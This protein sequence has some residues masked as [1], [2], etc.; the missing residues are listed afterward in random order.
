MKKFIKISGMSC[1]HCS[2]RVLK[3]LNSIPRVSSATIDLT[4]GTAT[5]ECDSNVTNDQ[6][7]NA[8]LDL[9]FAVL[10]IE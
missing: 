6:L 8:I 10:K 7:T 5:V 2:S 1:S 9:G 4:T 3:A